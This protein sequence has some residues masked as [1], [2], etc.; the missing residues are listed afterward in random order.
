MPVLS[1][2]DTLITS[3][4]EQ[5][6]VLN[7]QFSSQCSTWPLADPPCCSHP[8]NAGGFEF[9]PISPDSIMS[10]LAHLPSGKS[11]G[12]DLITCELLKLASTSVSI[13]LADLFNRS[14][15]T[16]I[17]PNLWKEA[18]ISPLLKD[19]KDANQPRS[20]RPIALLSCTAKVLERLVYDQLVHFCFENDILPKEQFGFLQGRS[21]EWQLLAILED[22]HSALDRHCNVHATFLDAAKAFDR[23][24]HSVLLDMLHGIGVHGIALEWFHSYLSGRHIRTRVAGS[25]SPALPVTSGSGVPQVPFSGHCCFRSTSKTY[26]R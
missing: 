18:I 8:L 26:P 23:V 12:P 24:D 6:R 2:N 21:A 22:W 14:L 3:P 20:Y 10:K 4:L 17:F 15:S 11:S 7:E 19:G 16:G 25:L 5:A 1:V 9:K 13:S